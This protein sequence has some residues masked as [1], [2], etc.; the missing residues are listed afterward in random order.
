MLTGA[1]PPVKKSAVRH[2]ANKKG[3]AVATPFIGEVP[4]RIELL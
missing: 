1:V 2:L 3:A 4:S